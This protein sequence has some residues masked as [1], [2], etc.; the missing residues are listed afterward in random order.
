MWEDL[1]H[2]SFPT[3]SV[4][5]ISN[6]FQP[7]TQNEDQHLSRFEDVQL[8]L[9]NSLSIKDTNETWVDLNVCKQKDV[10][11]LIEGLI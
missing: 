1:P 11:N 9:E 7:F 4:N 8:N 2:N 3:V 6:Y 10:V 5:T